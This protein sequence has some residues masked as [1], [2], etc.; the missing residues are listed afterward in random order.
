MNILY[1]CEYVSF[2]LFFGRFRLW[3]NWPRDKYAFIP[4]KMRIEVSEV[5]GKVHFGVQKRASF[6]SFVEEPYTRFAVK[7]EVGGDYKLT[8]IPRV[9]NLIIA[10]LKKYIR[11][12]VC[13]PKAY[14]TRILWPKKWWPEGEDEYK[15][16]A[17]SSSTP[18][19]VSGNVE[20]VAGETDNTE[21]SRDQPHIPVKSETATDNLQLSGKP[22]ENTHGASLL[23][24]T[25][26]S[27]RNNLSKWLIKPLIKGRET[28]GR[29]RKNRSSTGSD[30][31]GDS[32]DSSDENGEYFE[33]LSSYQ[34][35]LKDSENLW[36][37]CVRRAFF[38]AVANGRGGVSKS[39]IE[40]AI[41]S[42]VFAALERHKIRLGFIRA[43][44]Q[45]TL[46]SKRSNSGI[47]RPQEQFCSIDAADMLPLSERRSKASCRETA[48]ATKA[49]NAIRCRSYS[50]SDFRSNSLKLSAYFYFKSHAMKTGI[51]SDTSEERDMKSMS[52]PSRLG[53]SNAV[54]ST[55]GRG[56][57]SREM[58]STLVFRL[59]AKAATVRDRT[60]E[61]GNKFMAKVEDLEVKKSHTSVMRYQNDGFVINTAPRNVE[62]SISKDPY[63]SKN[64]ET[65]QGHSKGSTLFGITRQFEKAKDALKSGL[66][67]P[68]LRKSPDK[69]LA[70][71]GP[72]TAECS[73]QVDSCTNGNMQSPVVSR[74]SSPI[75]DNENLRIRISSPCNTTSSPTGE[76]SPDLLKSNFGSYNQSIDLEKKAEELA[77]QARAQAIS[78]AS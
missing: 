9:S 11:N 73:D 60:S 32:G 4:V 61:L 12:K 63:L 50:V 34:D 48:L 2:T 43:I 54:F 23:S 62:D 28:P 36:Q 37:S 22:R 47:F 1:A 20:S 39:D 70:S 17:P 69:N 71:R 8:D 53:G 13:Y 77:W 66:R 33:E 74:I 25:G 44:S 75:Q 3:M 35:S 41:S 57:Q 51:L 58:T 59:A 52:S 65:H 27:V 56:K 45:T 40:F 78:E 38:K 31:H 7:S 29:W 15:E 46:Y 21:P 6:L 49:K 42:P 5:I 67:R 30:H 10:K 26:V 68:E 55:I 14:K 64:G 16:T 24:S 19:E 76:C 18:E 72:P